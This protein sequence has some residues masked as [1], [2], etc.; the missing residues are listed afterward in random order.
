MTARL[1]QSLFYSRWHSKLMVYLTSTSVA[2]LPAC[3]N[4]DMLRPKRGS[5]HHPGC[6]LLFVV[7]PTAMLTFDTVVGLL[8]SYYYAELD[9]APLVPYYCSEWGTSP[10]VPYY[11]AELN[12]S[13]EMNRPSW[14]VLPY[15]NAQ[16]DDVGAQQM[17]TPWHDAHLN[18][19]DDAPASLPYRVQPRDVVATTWPVG[20]ST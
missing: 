6:V 3:W 18:D 1:V 9:N 15:Y 4:R 19:D 2:A 14:A 13:A 7:R 10:Q 16:L 8:T 5:H 12:G 17:M 20:V 11:D